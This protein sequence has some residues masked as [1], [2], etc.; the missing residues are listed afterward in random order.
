M[1]HDDF[2][3]YKPVVVNINEYVAYSI[4]CLFFAFL[5]FFL[6]NYVLLFVEQFSGRDAGHEC[7]RLRENNALLFTE[8]GG[9]DITDL[10]TMQ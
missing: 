6:S 2:H 8:Q 10:Q 5:T 1:K 9:T 7:S 4:F 3:N